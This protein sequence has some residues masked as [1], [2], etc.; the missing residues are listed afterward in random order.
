VVMFPITRKSKNWRSG[1]PDY[2]TNIPV[3]FCFPE[4]MT[5]TGV[6]Q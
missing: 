1:I 4:P 5:V 6:F 3:R 2:I